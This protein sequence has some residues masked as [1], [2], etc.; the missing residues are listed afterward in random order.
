MSPRSYGISNSTTTE[1]A[2]MRSPIVRN[3]SSIPAPVTAE[4]ATEPGWLPTNSSATSD[5]MSA[6]LNTNSSGTSPAP[7]SVSTSRTAKICP[8]GSTAVESTTWMSRSPST[9]T[10]SVL[11][12][13]STRPCG[14]RRTK[15][16]VSL[17]NT[18]SPPG[19]ASRRVVGSS[20]ANNRFSTNTPASVR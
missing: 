2:R 13:D 12:N 3:K 8:A 19:S 9:A 16:T 14:R 15:P 7:M 5:A 4:I 6:L 1:M 17:T 11:L 18:G 10:S 20:V